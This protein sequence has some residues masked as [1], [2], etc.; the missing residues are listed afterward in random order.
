MEHKDEEL[1]ECN[2]T[3]NAG[4]NYFIEMQTVGFFMA[5]SADEVKRQF[6]SN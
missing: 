5:Q 1:K 4:H 2:I 6:F 3:I